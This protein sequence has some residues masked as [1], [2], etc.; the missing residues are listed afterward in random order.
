MHDEPHPFTVAAVAG[1]TLT[2]W[3]RA[4][5]E[6]RP[7]APLEVVRILEH[8][9]VAV[10][11]DG[12]ATVSFVRLPV[13]ADDGLSIIPLYAE[14]PVVVVPKDHAVEALESA[15]LADLTDENL[16]SGSYDEAI[17]LVAANVGVAVVPQSIARLYARKDIVARP[18]T[19][20]AETRIG[21]AW[22]TAT[23]DERVAERIEEF[24]G[25]VRGRTAHSSR[26]T[27]TPPK[28]PEQRKKKAA[29]QRKVRGIPGQRKRRGGR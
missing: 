17:A 7:D 8:E 24:V 18:V 1:V 15:M 10:L 16:L 23:T 20:A 14:T 9:Q 28:A 12:S 6:R 22:V 2:K 3:T 21:L 11:R 5:Q 13:D 29:P 27:P 26:T 4:W 25:I 19:D